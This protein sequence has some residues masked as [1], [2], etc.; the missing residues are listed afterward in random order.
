MLAT[1]PSVFNELP[2]DTELPGLSAA[3][4]DRM[5]EILK[6][7]PN[8]A[9]AHER[10]SWQSCTMTEA[11]YQPGRACRVVYS[12]GKDSDHERNDLLYARWARRMRPHESA[13][14]LSADGGSLQIF[15]YPRDRRMRQIRSMRR[16]DWLRDAAE[17]W[18][19]I[20]NGAGS[21]AQDGWRCTPIK[22]VP[23]SRLVCRLKARWT[24]DGT[25]KWVR[26]YVR[27]S[28][29]ND[30]EHV[31]GTMTNIRKSLMK[32]G[33]S[34][35]VPAPLGILPARHL[36]ATEFVRGRSLKELAVEGCAVEVASICKRLAML[37]R[38]CP[39]AIAKSATMPSEGIGEMLRD[40]SYASVERSKLCGELHG[41]NSQTPQS[42]DTLGLVHGDLHSGQVILRGARVCVVDWDR[43]ALGDGTRDIL[44]LAL[45]FAVAPWLRNGDGNFATELASAC[46]AAWRAAG[47]PWNSASARWWAVQSLVQRAWGFM[48]H[49]RPDWPLTS[50]RLLEQARHI[51]LHGLEIE[52]L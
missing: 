32:S 7:S 22:Y 23:E 17:S 9:T 33:A 44:N 35:D 18:F 6:A 26:A 12:L 16:D 50:K 49:L 14:V 19:R 37:H 15:R 13:I 24:A 43:A 45:D 5:L 47:G 3:H 41:W 11:I 20:E 48:R 4:P 10:E 46:V 42:P 36:L 8:V 28:R 52:G 51:W 29:R 39:R 34:V 31:F 21:M 40:L 25:D 27:I 30:A 2:E 1:S 38:H